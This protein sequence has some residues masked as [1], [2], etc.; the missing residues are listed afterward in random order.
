[1]SE[2]A[3]ALISPKFKNIL[4]ATDFSPSSE[5]A[6]P[7]ARAIAKRYGATVHMLH[8]V[9]PEPMIGPLG[10]P[11]IDV[12]RE[13][14]AVR[15]KLNHLTCSY[16][17]MGIPCLEAVRRGP[18]WDVVSQIVADRSIDLIVLGTHGHRGFKH[19]V[20]GSV[21]ER[22]FRGASCPVLTVGPHVRAAGLIAFATVLYATDFSPDSARA[23]EYAVSLAQRNEAKLILF[24]AVEESPEIMALYLKEAAAAAQQRLLTLVPKDPQISCS[25]LAEC[26]PAADMILKVAEDTNANLIVM[27]IHGGAFASAHVPWPIAHQVVCRAC[28]P[29]LTVRE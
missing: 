29:V 8:V 19:L 3:F 17:F 10:V 2:S 21:A 14:R 27:G 16:D 25:V 11:Y 18:V 6:V 9:G 5:A 12:E 4:F 13:D 24:H 7:Y 23:W 1:M 22:V 26:G 15:E 28:C 20:L